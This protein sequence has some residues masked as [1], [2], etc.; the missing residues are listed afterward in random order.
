MLGK[1]MVEITETFQ[2][3]IGKTELSFP[4]QQSLQGE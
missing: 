1:E 3:V 2:A 4:W